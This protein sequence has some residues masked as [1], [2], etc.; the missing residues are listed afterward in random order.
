ML[1]RIIDLSVF[2]L[3]LLLVSECIPSSAAVD[4][5]GVL[6]YLRG[7]TSAI[8]QQQQQQQQKQQQRTTRKQRQQLRRRTQKQQRDKKGGGIE[9]GILIIQ[10]AEDVVHGLLEAGDKIKIDAS[11]IGRGVH[12]FVDE[13]GEKVKSD[14]INVGKGVTRGWDEVASVVTKIVTQGIP[15]QIN[16]LP[17]LPKRR[18][19]KSTRLDEV[20]QTFSSVL[21]SGNDIDTAQLLKACR[22]HV[23]LMRTGGPSLRLVAKD[24]ESNV[25]KAENAF[26]HSPQD[27]RTLSSLLESERISGIHNESN[28]A[29]KS[30]AMG[31]LWIRRSLAFQLDLYAC[32]AS[33]DG[34]GGGLGGGGTTPRDAAYSAY[35]RHL[36]PYHGWALRKV[37]P[38][39]LSHMPDR[40]TFLAKFGGIGIDELTDDHGREISRKLRSLIATWKPLLSSW[41]DEFD[42]LGLE[43]IR[44]V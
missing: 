42:R 41:K 30:A 43:D 11:N 23:A 8:Q 31:L 2:F 27:S 21:R 9:L 10:L 18:G 12:I 36:S 33:N 24:L 28:L 16:R 4:S 37:F 40:Q 15:D 6:P 35:T 25:Q 3:L 26:R 7:G 17:F 32:I 29:E 38:A 5:G 22:A 14:A 19:F 34:G 44:R 20:C 39:S 1:L 13:M